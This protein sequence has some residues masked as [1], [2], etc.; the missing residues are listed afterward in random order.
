[1]APE[2]TILL[3]SRNG[4]LS[5]K[6]GSGSRGNGFSGSVEGRMGADGTLWQKNGTRRARL[7]ANRNILATGGG[8]KS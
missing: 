5:E 4:K 6:A 2:K 8:P 7:E 3:S 1:M